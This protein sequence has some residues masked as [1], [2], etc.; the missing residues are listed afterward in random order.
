MSPGVLGSHCQD[1]FLLGFLL[2]HLVL[3][4]LHV[5]LRSWV[6]SL[7][8][9]HFCTVLPLFPQEEKVL[10]TLESLIHAKKKNCSP[11]S[12]ET[13]LCANPSHTGGGGPLSLTGILV[14]FIGKFFLG[15][16]QCPD[17]LS[18]FST[19]QLNHYITGTPQSMC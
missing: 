17:H 9:F 10:R 16:M 5:L 6:H 15:Q 11:S 18:L 13:Q 14:L 2:L 3:V 19:S 12:L 7:T 8:S 1:G 4:F